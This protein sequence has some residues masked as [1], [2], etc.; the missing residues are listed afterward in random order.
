[1]KAAVCA[2]GKFEGLKSRRM[3][4]LL[5]SVSHHKCN[6]KDVDKRDNKYYALELLCRVFHGPYQVSSSHA[7]K[8]ILLLSLIYKEDNEAERV[9]HSR[10]RQKSQSRQS[11]SPGS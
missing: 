4:K 2:P 10:S 6:N 7:M 9:I 3:E 1:M 8:S 11:Q 5:P